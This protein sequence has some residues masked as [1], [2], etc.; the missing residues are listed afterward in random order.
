M[1][2]NGD[3]SKY[4]PADAIMFLS[5]LDL[6]GILSVAENGR[7]LTLSFHNGF[8]IDAHSAQGD[9]KILQQ[10]TFNRSLT[11]DQVKQIRQI[12]VETGMPIR[13]ILAQIDL[14][15]LSTVKEILQAGMREV[16]L[17][18]FLLDEGAFHFTDT[19]VE[20]DDAETKLDACKLAISIAAQ[21]DEYRDF[22]KGI[23]SLD[24]EFSFSAKG[25]QSEARPAAEMAVLRLLSTCRTFRQV[26]E[27]APGDSG[28]VIAAIKR[29]IENKTITLLPTD[30][31]APFG[32]TRF[33]GGSGVWI[34]QTNPQD[35][36]AEQGT[37][38]AHRGTG[39]LL[40]GVFTTAY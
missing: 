27:K 10:L 6:S 20:A 3:L 30:T 1:N 17:E 2:F 28:S 19:P 4:H 7:M 14:F 26:L 18:M 35:A 13:S 40:Q 39:D 29:Q 33:Q 32:G 23:L 11:A 34:I 25:L 16:L 37:V 15:P 9:T 21:S 5:Q 22:E 31:A 12:Q 8:I 36:D 38:E 24:R